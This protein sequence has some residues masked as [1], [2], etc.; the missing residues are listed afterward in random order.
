MRASGKHQGHGNRLK[1]WFQ[2]GSHQSRVGRTPQCPNNVYRA[3]LNSLTAALVPPT[4]RLSISRNE[5]GQKM[6]VV[7]TAALRGAVR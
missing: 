3:K 2:R 7:R 6:T 5:E 4:L 1:R